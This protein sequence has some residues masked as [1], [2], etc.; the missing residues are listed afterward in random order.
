MLGRDAEKRSNINIPD[1][2]KDYGENNRLRERM[3]GRVSRYSGW[4]DFSERVIST[5]R[6][7]GSER[8][9]YLHM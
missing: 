1:G 4:G 6:T 2:D 8:E 3:L 5:L 7:E 9:S